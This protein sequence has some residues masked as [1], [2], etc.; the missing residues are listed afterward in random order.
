MGPLE[1]LEALTPEDFRKIGREPSAAA[2][3]IREKIDLLGQQS[4]ALRATGIAAFRR[5]PLMARYADA[6]NAAVME[7]K[8]IHAVESE[9]TQPE[10]SALMALAASMRV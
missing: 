5:S 2:A 8:P 7:G 1:E 6:L 3:R 9:L 4:Y 10:L